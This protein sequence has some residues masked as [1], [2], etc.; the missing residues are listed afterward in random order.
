MNP[1]WVV[2]QVQEHL[3]FCITMIDVYELTLALPK[4]FTYSMSHRGDFLTVR[5][6]HE[7]VHQNTDGFGSSCLICS[8]IVWSGVAA[9]IYVGK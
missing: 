9:R 2:P 8:C 5:W 1:F 7:R 3:A 4:P 6:A